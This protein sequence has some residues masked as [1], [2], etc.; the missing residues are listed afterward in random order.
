[1]QNRLNSEFFATLKGLAG[2]NN[3]TNEE[4]TSLEALAN[5]RLYIAYKASPVWQRYI[6]PSESRAISTI[7][8]TNLSNT[9]TTNKFTALYTKVGKAA[10]NLGLDKDTD[11]YVTNN[12]PTSSD[13]V[14][15][16]A[17]NRWYHVYAP[18]YTISQITNVVTFSSLGSQVAV[19]NT[20]DETKHAKPSDVKSWL[21]GSDYGDPTKVDNGHDI[22]S[23]SIIPFESSLIPYVDTA[24]TKPKNVI[25]SEFIRIHG[26][27][28][29][30]NQSAREYQ[31]YV[32]D[33]GANLLNADDSDRA[34]VT[35]RKP[36]YDGAS[37]VGNS[38]TIIT[39]LDNALISQVPSEFFNYAVYGTYADFLRMDGQH[40]KALIEDEIAQKYLDT[41]LEQNDIINNKNNIN[42][43]F[44]TYVNKQSR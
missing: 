10:I 3:F 13:F 20:T 4:V 12:R 31:F 38:Q 22:T 1:M 7:K 27:R 18:N 34:F 14:F 24:Q 26:T 23:V 21:F 36:P 19:Q 16:R 39:D 5:R 43:K 11:V 42:I 33:D 41:E 44:S 9:N 30:L 32:D 37:D 28:A 25:I 15:Y 2:V 35:Y 17:S 40:Q 8:Y 29:Y 6:M